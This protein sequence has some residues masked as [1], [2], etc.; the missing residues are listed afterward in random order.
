[1]GKSREELLEHY[2][3]NKRNNRL[4]K[5]EELLEAWGFTPR[6]A[7]K[8]SAVWSRGRFT[9]TAPND[10]GRPIHPRYFSTAIRLIDQIKA[11]EN[12]G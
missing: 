12:D 1:M 6:D 8:E 7:T 4:R 3:R 5:L 11:E 9:F 10:H 2:R